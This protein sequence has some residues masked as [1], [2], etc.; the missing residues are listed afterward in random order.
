MRPSPLCAA[1]AVLALMLLGGHPS[2][3]RAQ[4]AP[5][6]LVVRLPAD[7]ELFIDGQPTRSTSAERHFITPPLRPGAAYQYT[8]QVRFV[9]GEHTYVIRQVARVR[10]SRETVVTFINPAGRDGEPVYGAAPDSSEN[11]YGAPADEPTSPL[12]AAN[13]PPA[14]AVAP[15]DEQDPWG[16]AGPPGSNAPLSWGVGRG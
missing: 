6:T 14:R 15:L 12:P 8:L 16:G 13:N 2:A 4:S 9:R 10:A 5:A 3:A 7:A 1:G 11:Y